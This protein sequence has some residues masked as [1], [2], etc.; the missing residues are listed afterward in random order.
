[1][2]HKHTYLQMTFLITNG[3]ASSGGDLDRDM[4]KISS[5][6]ASV[7]IKLYNL[8]SIHPNIGKVYIFRKLFHQGIQKWYYFCGKGKSENNMDD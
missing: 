8:K 3:H 1:M 5:K 7:H 6:C 2:V 4:P